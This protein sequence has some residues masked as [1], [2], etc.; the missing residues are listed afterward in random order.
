[1][2]IR[3]MI[4]VLLVVVFAVAM[5][6]INFASLGSVDLEKAQSQGTAWVSRT[7]QQGPCPIQ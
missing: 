6:A 4:L 3:A 5:G 1:M 7:P 2:N